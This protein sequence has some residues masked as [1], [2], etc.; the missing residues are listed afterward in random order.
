MHIFYLLEHGVTEDSLAGKL[1]SKAGVVP[2]S[3]RLA[4]LL[5]VQFS[6]NLDV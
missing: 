6:C 2:E 3:S 5:F 1:D 4:G